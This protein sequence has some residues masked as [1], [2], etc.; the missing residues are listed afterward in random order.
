MALLLIGIASGP[1]T[2]QTEPAKTAGQATDANGIPTAPPPTGLQSP[3]PAATNPIPT[4]KATAL[5]SPT[6]IQLRGRVP[7]R[8]L[9]IDDAVAIALGNNRNLGLAVEALS[10]TQGRVSETR[11]ALNPTLGAGFNYTRLNTGQSAKIGGNSITIVNADQPVL[12]LS[13]TLPIDISG[14]LR[15]AVQQSQ[16]QEIAARIDINRARNQIVLDTK[17]AFYNILRYQALVAVAQDT[18]QNTLDRLS[19]AQKKFTAGT[20]ARFDVI[21]AETDVANARQQLITA[22]SNVSFSLATLNSNMGISIDSPITV[23]AGNSIETPPGVAPA[24]AYTPEAPVSP[25]N[26]TPANSPADASG[27]PS[28]NQT[29]N[30]SDNSAANRI[31]NSV[32]LISDPISYGADYKAVV[33]EALTTRPE[34]LEADANL[35][36]AQKGIQLAR[37][38]SLPALNLSL[39]TQYSPNAAGFSPQ[40]TSGSLV[41]GFSFPIF[42]GGVSRARVQQARADVGTAETERRNTVDSVNLEVRNAYLT[43][44]QARDR[45]AVA[46]QGLAEAQESFRLSRVRYN[47][48]VSTLVEV[49]DAQ[50]ALTQAGQNQVN[51][52]YD[53]N[54]ARASLDKA[55]GRY[56]YVRNAPGYPTP[57]ST[58]VTGGSLTRTTGGQR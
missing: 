28:S 26:T 34:V 43:L 29:G 8:P 51:A 33:N 9:T 53:Y 5:S 12:S 48:G 58:K 57:P 3:L 54:N 6:L 39:G 23:T 46:N 14:S 30:A 47:N 44:V 49:S 2:A 16:F 36:A 18:L 24:A 42:D 41:V 31:A 27:N 55:A 17:T 21:R 25:N 15:T 35:A 22:N 32:A 20:V 10:R 7:N 4:L 1:I 52:L 40:T 13:A 37:R 11:A 56:S 19:D 50:A 38:S 45:V